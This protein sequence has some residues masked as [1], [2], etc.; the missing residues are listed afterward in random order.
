MQAE[1]AIKAEELSSEEEKS[2]EDMKNSHL[3]KCRF[4][5]KKVP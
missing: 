3:V 2:E 4:Y 1:Q 5:R